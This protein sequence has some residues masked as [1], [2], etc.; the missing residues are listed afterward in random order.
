MKKIKIMIGSLL[1]IFLLILLPSVSAVE[2]NAAKEIVNYSSK[3]LVITLNKLKEIYKENDGEPTFFI[4]YTLLIWLLKVLRWI[5]VGIILVILT[6]IR[7]N[8][9]NQTAELSPNNI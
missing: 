7:K 5:D 8:I 6:I 3:T 1:A 4:L 2:A 9:G